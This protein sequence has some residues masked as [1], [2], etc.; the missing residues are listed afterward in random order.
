MDLDW[1]CPYTS[2]RYDIH[3]LRSGG[4]D[5]DHII[6]R[7]QRT[8]DSLD[9]LVITFKAVNAWKTNTTAIDFIET[10][11]GKPV[12]GMPNLSIVSPKAYLELV[13]DLKRKRLPHPDDQRRRDNRCKRMLTK[14]SDNAASKG[15]TPRDLTMTSHLVTLASS[16]IRDVFRDEEQL[17][18]IRS[19]PGPITKKVRMSLEVLGALAKVNPLVLNSEGELKTKTEIRD[20]S[21]LHHAVDAITLGLA[22]SVVPVDGG[23][24]ALM[25]KRNLLPA[26][27][28]RLEATGAFRF[29]SSGRAE[30]RPLHPETRASIDRCLAECRVATHLSRS[31]H[32]ATLEKTTWRVVGHDGDQVEI[33]QQSR[34]EK[35]GAIHRK[36]DKV[37][38]KRLLGI[39]PRGKSKLQALKGAIVISDNYGVALDPEP[40]VIPF[41]QVW[42]R[43]GTIRRRNNG[44]TP[45]LLRNG[46]MIRVRSGKFAGIWKVFSVKDAQARIMIDMGTPDATKLLNKTPGHKINVSIKTLLTDGLEICETGYTGVPLNVPPPD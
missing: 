4:V 35:T 19:I 40:E 36:T 25:L 6:P 39:T 12:P 33:R 44:L 10:H 45:R 23:V 7:S 41:H 27:R 22:T 5:L 1:T 14:H 17:P 43:I 2:A 38:A 13:D 21:H 24:W 26:E 3:Q 16:V 9:S 46:M 34:D 8:S 31:R 18:I 28:Q 32:G 30:L 11:G 42:K 20:I 37:N 15:F 29:D